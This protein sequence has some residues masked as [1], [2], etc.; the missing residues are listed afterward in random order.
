MQ[1]S[2]IIS[3]IQTSI[4]YIE[5]IAFDR[6]FLLVTGARSENGGTIA[7]ALVIQMMASYM[8]GQNDELLNET[9]IHILLLTY[10]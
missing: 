6:L 1:L 2:D 5:L 7:W 3:T 10:R 4:R 8:K 9:V